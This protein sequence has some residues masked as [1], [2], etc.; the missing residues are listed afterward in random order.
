VSAALST[1]E[2]LHMPG[3]VARERTRVRRLEHKLARAR[4]G[5]RRRRRVLLALAQLKER[6]TNRRKDWA[7]KAS[8]DIARRFDLIKVEDL[9]IKNMTRSAKGTLQDPGRN[10]GQKTGLTAS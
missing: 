6:E 3:L 1:G 7:E 2:L 10:V 5:S 9:H 8:T 4:R